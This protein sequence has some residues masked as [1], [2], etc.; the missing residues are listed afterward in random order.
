M[1]SYGDDTGVMCCEEGWC[2]LG[3]KI[4]VKISDRVVKGGEGSPLSG[5]L[6]FRLVQPK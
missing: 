3:G 1:E 2:I 6:L 5:G 4:G